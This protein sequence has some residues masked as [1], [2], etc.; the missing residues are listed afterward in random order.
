MGT[1]QRIR[2]ARTGEGSRD[3]LR[4]V[5]QVPD[6]A[7]VTQRA[8]FGNVRSREREGPEDTGRRRRGKRCRMWNREDGLKNRMKLEKKDAG[9]NE[10]DVPPVQTW[11]HGRGLVGVRTGESSWGG[12]G[13]RLAKALLKNELEFVLQHE[14]RPPANT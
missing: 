11:H 13:P 12:Q 14:K 5:A 8:R 6:R 10:K 7:A 9:D 4:A 2:G 3:A 1:R